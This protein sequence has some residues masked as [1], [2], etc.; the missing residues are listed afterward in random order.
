M[1]WHRSSKERKAKIKK[2]IVVWRNTAAGRREIEFI[3]GNYEQQ[4]NKFEKQMGNFRNIKFV[5]HA[6]WTTRQAK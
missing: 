3:R 1:W 2:Q 5:K 4:C 6:S